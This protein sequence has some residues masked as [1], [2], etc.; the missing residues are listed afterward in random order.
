MT[1]MYKHVI[2]I[3][4]SRRI[5]ANKNNNKIPEDFWVPLL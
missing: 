1:A 2:M 4:Y 5:A 3:N